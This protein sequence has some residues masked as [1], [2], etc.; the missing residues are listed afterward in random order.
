MINKIARLQIKKLN[1]RISFQDGT[2]ISSILM[3]CSY[4][5]RISVIT[6]NSICISSS[7]LRVQALEVVFT[8]ISRRTPQGPYFRALQQAQR[9]AQVEVLGKQL[10]NQRLALLF[11]KAKVIHKVLERLG[12]RI[13]LQPVEKILGLDSQFKIHKAAPEVEEFSDNQLAALASPRPA[14]LIPS[15]QGKTQGAPPDFLVNKRQFSRCKKRAD[16]VLV[17][18]NLQP[19]EAVFLANSLVP[20]H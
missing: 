15:N 12:Q 8:E 9:E 18:R 14:Y 6:K 5:K 20:Q 3:L 2:S 16:L 13:P 7:K 17:R 11:L 10:R 19:P 4:P 1:T